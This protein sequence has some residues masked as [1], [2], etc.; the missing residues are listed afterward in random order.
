MVNFCMLR[1][2]FWLKFIMITRHRHQEFFDDIIDISFISD[3]DAKQLKESFRNISIPDIRT[4]TE[5]IEF[6]YPFMQKDPL[7][8]YSKITLA[9]LCKTSKSFVT[10]VT[11]RD[12]SEVKMRKGR[13][14]VMLTQSENQIRIWLDECHQ[15]H[16]YPS[17]QEFKEKCV[18]YLSKQKFAG[19]FS[20]QYFDKLFSLIAP[21]YTLQTAQ[22]PDQE[23]FQVSSDTIQDFFQKLENANFDS[24]PPDLIE[25]ID[26]TGFGS[27][28]RRGNPQIKIIVPRNY[29]GPVYTCSGKTKKLMST[30]VGIS[31]SGRMLK[32]GIITDRETVHPDANRCPFYSSIHY[33]A[34]KAFVNTEIF[35]HFLSR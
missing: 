4:K 16:V 13:P 2:Q 24:I 23:R 14:T 26:E 8:K 30:L 15:N 6:L 21:D 29:I 19:S 11:C 3:A 7:Y 25:N 27:F 22:Q 35:E 31:A 1:P 33:K 17:K 12:K 9:K 5:L 18:F 10:K 28:K 20:G 32:P 34:P